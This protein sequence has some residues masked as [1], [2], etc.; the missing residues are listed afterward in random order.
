M[1]QKEKRRAHAPPHPHPPHTHTAPA[2]LIP[3]HPAPSHS[4]LTCTRRIGAAAAAVTLTSAT[5]RP[6]LVLV[7]PPPGRTAGY[8]ER[9][10]LSTGTCLLVKRRSMDHTGHDRTLS[11]RHAVLYAAVGRRAPRGHLPRP[12]STSR[13]ALSSRALAFVFESVVERVYINKKGQ[14]KQNIN[15]LKTLP[16][17]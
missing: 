4:S 15:I 11:E 13:T 7:E 2:F 9:L 12:A 10:R 17:G 16:R 5:M 1:P 6:V 14:T 3:F 8:R